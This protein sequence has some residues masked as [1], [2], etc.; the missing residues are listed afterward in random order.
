MGIYAT[1]GA[2][3]MVLCS[4]CGGTGECDDG[5]PCPACDGMMENPE[6]CEDVIADLRAQLENLKEAVGSHHKSLWCKNCEILVRVRRQRD[7]LREMLCRNCEEEYCAGCD[8]M[9][10]VKD[11]KVRSRPDQDYSKWER[12]MLED[13]LRQ[14]TADYYGQ[15]EQTKNLLAE[16]AVLRAQLAEVKERHR[17]YA[18]GIRF[19]IGD[20]NR[21]RRE[22][23]EPMNSDQ[24]EIKRMRAQLAEYKSLVGHGG[25][26]VI[27]RC[28]TCNTPFADLAASSYVYCWECRAKEGE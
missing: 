9:E 13:T 21:A 12:G 25:M 4:A 24:A 5:K 20:E 14:Y 28:P 26:A 16:R 11:E 18:H 27:K 10:A 2:R 19:A 17:V 3:T 23:G 7:A 8:V 6:S 15:L 22:S 1:S